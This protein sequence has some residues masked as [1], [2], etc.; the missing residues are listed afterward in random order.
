MPDFTYRDHIIDYVINGEGEQ[1][2]L[3]IFDAETGDDITSN[4]LESDMDIF[5]H[6]A[7]N[8]SVGNPLHTN[9]LKKISAYVLK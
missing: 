1:E 3:Q 5:G 4:F 6:M 7:Y 2:S 8:H 9:I